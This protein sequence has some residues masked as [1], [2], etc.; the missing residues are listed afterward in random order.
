MTYLSR[1][2]QV[3][4]APLQTLLLRD[5]DIGKTFDELPK[6]INQGCNVSYEAWKKRRDDRTL[7]TRSCKRKVN[8]PVSE[9]H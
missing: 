4:Q 9:L 7:A 8:G 2:H 6:D 5:S 1:T 3:V